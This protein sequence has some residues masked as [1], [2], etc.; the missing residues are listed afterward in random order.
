VGHGLTRDT[1]VPSFN[2]IAAALRKTTE[3]LAREVVEPSGAPPD[4]SEFEWAVAQSV[5]TM[6]GI[7][8]LLATR[9]R[10]QGP[11]AWQS[12]LDHEREQCL[13]RDAVIDRLLERLDSA[14]R[15][16]RVAC[17]AMK[18]AALRAL[19]VYS[20]GE[21]PM[22][23][24]DLLVREVDL[25][26]TAAMMTRLGYVG[27]SVP[28]REIIYELP[29]DAPVKIAGEHA[30]NPLKVEVHTSVAEPLPVRKV[31][32]TARL[33]PRDAR[34]GINAYPSIGALLL[35]SLLRA[36]SNMRAHVL[37]QIQLNDIAMVLRRMGPADWAAFLEQS[38]TAEERWW[39]Y[40][41]LALTARYYGRDTPTA[42]LAELRAAC[43]PVL[44][45][46]SERGALTDVSWSNLRI[47]AFPGMTWAR[48][49]GEVLGY[50]R[51]RVL[52]P[53]HALATIDV[54][55][56]QQPQLKA[57]PWY[58]LSHG[59]RIVRWLLSRP[60]RVQTL[61]SVMAT[62]RDASS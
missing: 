20:P 58:Q 52:P 23:D 29:R 22:G 33:Q 6:Q 46:V 43:P 2:A 49:P 54:A 3:H 26:V 39:M 9:V 5:A 56:D 25:P 41:P 50:M 55:V 18:G 30:D 44:R 60:P 12:F 47:S 42:V 59:K 61:T 1:V 38:S 14:A 28:D 11:P 62:L 32:I 7:S 21:R 19:E 37:R 8:F 31:D 51:S 34:F 48:T 40:P 16:S 17:V 15:D 53:R 4:W 27:T 35:H 10:W 24:V 13:L 36:A 57:V 45:G